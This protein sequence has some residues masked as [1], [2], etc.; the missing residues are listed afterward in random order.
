MK[1]T[2][3]LFC[4]LL[5]SSTVLANT[6][7]TPV[8]RNEVAWWKQRFEAKQVE[9]AKIREQGGALP[10]VM[11]GDSITHNWEKPGRE[12][13]AYL[14]YRYGTILDLGYSGDRTEHVLWRL[15]N[16]ELDGLTPTLITLMI[17]T[18]NVRVNAPE[19]VAEGIRQI[20]AKIRAKAPG[21][22]LV[23]HPIFPREAAPDNELRQKNDKVNTLIQPLANGRDI[24]WVDVNPR[25]LDADGTLSRQ[26]MPDLLH[27]NA[28]GHGLW[29]DTLQPILDAYLSH[30]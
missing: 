30:K 26:I 18:N 16:G 11:I 7:I 28:L 22:I 6:A 15:D 13:L 20:V 27:P 29:F 24:L 25:F 23:L 14:N 12:Y 3:V 5:G 9:A 21:A 17:G 4:I 19:E 2:A 1:W 10:L 8:S